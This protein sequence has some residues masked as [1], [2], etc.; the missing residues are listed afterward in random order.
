MEGKKL[1]TR[2]QRVKIDKENSLNRL[3]KRRYE[4]G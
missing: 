1:S 2:E 3:G 4:N